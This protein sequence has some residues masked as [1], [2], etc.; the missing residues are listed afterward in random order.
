MIPIVLHQLILR[1]TYHPIKKSLI[2]LN[3]KKV[4]QKSVNLVHKKTFKSKKKLLN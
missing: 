4:A 2:N 1:Y 3:C